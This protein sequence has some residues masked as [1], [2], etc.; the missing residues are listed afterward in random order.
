LPCFF[1]HT[2]KPEQLELHVTMENGA[3]LI[4]P[5]AQDIA[6]GSRVYEAVV[7]SKFAHRM[8]ALERL[9]EERCARLESHFDRRMTV[10]E[11]VVQSRSAELAGQVTALDKTW[12]MAQ[13]VVMELERQLGVRLDADRDL[14]RRL[15][16]LSLKVAELNGTKDELQSSA[17]DQQSTVVQLGEHMQRLEMSLETVRSRCEEMSSAAEVLR[18]DAHG[19]SE[20]TAAHRQ[21]LEVMDAQVEALQLKVDQVGL[22][23]ADLVNEE[24][25]GAQFSLQMLDRISKKIDGI[26]AE[27]QK[28]QQQGCGNVTEF[29]ECSKVLPALSRATSECLGVT[30]GLTPSAEASPAS[31][32]RE[33]FGSAPSSCPSLPVQDVPSSSTLTVA[34][35]RAIPEEAGIAPLRTR[36][37]LLPRSYGN[38]PASPHQATRGTLGSMQSRAQSPQP[39]PQTGTGTMPPCMDT[40]AAGGLVKHSRMAHAGPEVP[41]VPDGH[42][43]AAFLSKN[44]R[45]ISKWSFDG[46]YP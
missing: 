30:K 29:Q 13:A 40:A 7:V 42:F 21:Y 35:R 43:A 44:L 39:V 19:T 37:V 16:E 27:S 6:E 11:V 22:K 5:L 33:R 26:R 10:L 41:H 31:S 23:V 12:A 20:T 3:P 38:R 14:E 32:R 34:S 25:H 28:Q 24:R 9:L 8:S 2:M 46:N 1:D 18:S 45:Q 36:V 17:A 15:S 4:S